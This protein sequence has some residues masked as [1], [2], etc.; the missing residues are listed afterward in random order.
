MKKIKISDVTLREFGKNAEQVSFSEKVETVKLLVKVGVDAIETAKITNPKVDA[1][2]LHTIAP[3]I[4]ETML[5]CPV[6][7]D[8]NELKSTF[9]ALSL[10]KNK[11][12]QISV[13][14][15]AVQMEFNCH[16]KPKA[17]LEAVSKQVALAKGL[18]EDVEFVAEDATRSDIDFLSEVLKAVINSGAKIVTLKDSAG[19][20]LP[21]ETSEFIK[22]VVGAVPELKNVELSFECSDAISMGVA[23][24]LSAVKEGVTILKTAS[25]VKEV[26]SLSA[27]AN[28]LRVKGDKIGVKASLND[29]LL[30]HSVG[31]MEK[32]LTSK[33][34]ENSPFDGVVK[35]ADEDFILSKDDD[36]NTVK[37]CTAMLGY[38]LSDEDVSKVYERFSSLAEKKRI[39]AKELDA[40]VASCALQVAPTYK[41]VS[42]VINSGNVMTATANIV[43][44][45]DGET[46]NGISL[47]DGPIDASFIA[48]EKI[49]GTH[50]ELDD[51][52]IQSVTEG[53]EAVGEALVKLRAFGKLYS[54]RGISTDIIGAS[55]RA[56][57]SALNKICFDNSIG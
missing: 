38:E 46:L 18:L 13:P 32:M 16:L 33:K 19:I 44:E 50:Y 39:G 6:G 26:L 27:L 57:I 14:T 40:I 1:L 29:S 28:T 11:R 7:L 48:I 35:T 42:Y 8:E 36:I 47:G 30:E 4:G 45:K 15:S 21:E 3:I 25:G 43:L 17:M 5:V 31:K 9:E 23:S 41:L 49:I 2:F 37:K 34:S 20:M 10:A 53:K 54:G 55:I 12:I 22:E 52:Q 56:Y 51:F 24:A